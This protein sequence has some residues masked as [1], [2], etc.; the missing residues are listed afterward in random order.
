MNKMSLFAC[1]PEKAN[2]RTATTEPPYERSLRVFR[3]SPGL[4]T[5]NCPFANLPEKRRTMWALTADEIKECRRLKPRLVAQ[6]E[7]YGVDTDGHLRQAS[8][9]GLRENKDVRQ[10]V[11]E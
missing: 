3:D 1:G 11:R 6:I 4:E 5:D 8:F 10:I 7:F 2:P 9:V